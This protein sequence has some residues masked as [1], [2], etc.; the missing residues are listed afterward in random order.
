MLV[1]VLPPEWLT[2]DADELLARL[3]RRGSRDALAA[4]LAEQDF[5]RI[6]VATTA[7][8]EREGRTIAEIAEAEGTSGV[9]ALIGVLIDERMQAS[10]IQF[11][12]HEDDLERALADGHTVI[13]SD[14]LPPGT[15][16]NPHPRLFGTFPRVLGRYAR[17]RGLFD[18]PEAVR[19]MTSLPAQQFR[20]PERGV[21]APGYWADLVAFDPRTVTDVGDYTDPVH[22]PRGVPW[23]CQGG[24]TVID[25]GV[26]LGCRAG[27]RLTPAA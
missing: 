13:G 6:L 8:H 25:E 12:M 21:L 18:L 4:A 7:S 1:T 27:R 26:H 20:I 15:G 11:S 9:E 24:R 17:E 3:S 5:G 16:G 10:M 22:P 23:V 2:G 19:R 14:G